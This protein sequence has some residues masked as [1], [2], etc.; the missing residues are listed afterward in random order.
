[1]AVSGENVPEA[2][3]D[4]GAVLEA[5]EVEDVER[6]EEQPE[7]VLT[8]EPDRSAG[9]PVVED[10]VETLLSDIGSSTVQ[11]TE[12]PE[13]LESTTEESI[14]GVFVSEPSVHVSREDATALDELFDELESETQST[15]ETTG[16][17]DSGGELE[18]VGSV[19]T[20]RRIATEDSGID[21][22]SETLAT[23]S[24][25]TAETEPTAAATASPEDDTGVEKQIR[26]LPHE[27]ASELSSSH[28][29]SGLSD[30]VEQLLGDASTDDPE[31]EPATPSEERPSVEEYAAE[32][33]EDVVDALSAAE[34]AIDEYKTNVL[35]DAHPDD[36]D[37]EWVSGDDVDQDA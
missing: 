23:A 10:E 27:P 6:L 31:P 19:G 15:P 4:V 3:T 30:R 17:S 28:A 29:A 32:Y 7:D 35:Y 26:K 12:E 1:M 36:T 18:L 24:E 37:F 8:V 2:E 34:A 9:E 20:E 21:E 5:Y 13:T 16:S 22:A 14:V 11:Q 33:S 25:S